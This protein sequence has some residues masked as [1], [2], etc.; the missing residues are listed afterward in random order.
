M[1]QGMSMLT[2]R[3]W[4]RSRRREV[5]GKQKTPLLLDLS[6]HNQ[7]TYS[8]ISRSSL[9]NTHSNCR[10][11]HNPRRQRPV[12]RR[13]PI[14]IRRIISRQPM[15]TAKIPAVIKHIPRPIRTSRLWCARKRLACTI[16]CAVGTSYNVV[17]RAR[18]CKG[19]GAAGV[20]AVEACCAAVDLASL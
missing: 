14:R 5:P 11:H 9:T 16:C 12:R 20:E 6:N 4:M 18:T 17:L 19:R 8:Y 15:L 7:H 10:Q 3:W 13:A 2:R 1:T